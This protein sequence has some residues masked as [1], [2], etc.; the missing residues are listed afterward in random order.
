[1]QAA[2]WAEADALAQN[3]PL[4]LSGVDRY[5]LR[6]WQITDGLVAQNLLPQS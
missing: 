6:E 2:S 1:M 4:I 3:D 5:E